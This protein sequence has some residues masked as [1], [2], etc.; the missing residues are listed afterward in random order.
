M[1]FSSIKKFFKKEEKKV[2]KVIEYE[3]TLLAKWGYA[4][5]RKILAPFV[6][7]FWIVDKVYI[8]VYY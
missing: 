5:L 1:N 6:R 4:I 7:L 3:E 8:L 2:E